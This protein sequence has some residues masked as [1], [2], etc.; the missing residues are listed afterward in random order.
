MIVLDESEAAETFAVLNWN[1]LCHKYATMAQHGYCASKALSWE[2]RRELILE[3]IKARDADF[4]CLQEIDMESFN[5]FFR[6]ELAFYHYKGVFWPKSRARTMGDKE[7]KVVDGCA[8]FYNGQKFI[9]LE[10][11]LIDFSNM[12]INRP[13]MKGEHD[14]FNRV[15]P[16][17]HVA[18]ITFF[19]NRATGSRMILAN[20][21]LFWDP[22]FEDVKLVQT[23]I[24]MEQVTKLADAWASIPACANKA[25]FRHSEQDTE[26]DPERPEPPFVEPGPSLEYS[27]GS[28]IPV[29][30]SGD[31]NAGKGSGILELLTRGALPA[32]HA[33]W[34]NNSYGSFT[35]DGV[36]TGLSLKSAYG[37]EARDHI[38]FTNYTPG[39]SGVI[40]YIWH[41]SSLTV[42][43]VL[44]NVDYDYLQKVPGFP[45][46]HFPSDHLSLYAEFAVE[47]RRERPKAV[48][49]DFGSTPRERR[50]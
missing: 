49:A 29:V 39:F 11:A 24:L 38:D 22:V 8:I 26:A 35:R 27:S 45:N 6:R 36:Y 32:N 17:D 20:A 23:A 2:Y 13:D 42:R 46:Y 18:V 14:I 50:G 48:E 10:K 12:A 25:M 3:E 41:S 30:V 43:R 1:I 9:L 19:E 15:M 40:D 21:H 37:G 33:D 28:Q 16:R 5:E 4:L 47:A 34:K 7:A 44:G 31:F